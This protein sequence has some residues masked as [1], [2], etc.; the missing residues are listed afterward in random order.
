MATPNDPLSLNE[1]GPYGEL[2]K[3]PNPGGLA[4]L[5]VPPFE[6]M[7]PFIEQRVGRKLT[8]DEV[9]AERLKHPSIVVTQEAAAKMSVARAA[10]QG[11]PAQ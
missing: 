6:S 10:R 5:G 11:Q 8:A 4:I 9:A 7:L 3:R 2:S 1:V